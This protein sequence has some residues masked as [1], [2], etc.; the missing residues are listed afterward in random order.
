MSTSIEKFQRRIM[1]NSGFFF[2]F[3]LLFILSGHQG[4]AQAG[5]Q[6]QATPPFSVRLM[7]IEA[8]A[9]TTFTY[10]AKL[11]N[12]ASSPRIFQL[13]AQLPAGWNISFKVEGIQVTSLS[14]EP[15]K[16]QDIN[17]D[18]QPAMAAKPAKYNIPVVAVTGPETLKLDLEAVVK[19]SYK[20][21]LSTPTGRLS[22]DVTEGKRKEIHLVVK[23]TGTIALDNL[24]L[25]A[26]TPPQ[27]QASFVPSNIAKLE[28]GKESEV[29]ATLSVPDKTI[30]G[31]YVT[32]FTVKNAQATADA[33]FRM[34]VKTSVLTGWLGM[35]VILLALGVVYYLIRK[36]GRR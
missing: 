9:N 15:G 19:G 34:T 22:G 28:P 14:L 23:N 17:I 7:N 21:E 25:S 30:A 32:T 35:L 10:N 8:A 24:E 18:I 12:D 2:Y 5:S 31:D 13:S 11:R 20:V 27:W 36:Y 33:A 26:Q 3:F 29:I 16:T 4:F 6:G 1:L